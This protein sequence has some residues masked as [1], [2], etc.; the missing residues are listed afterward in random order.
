MHKAITIMHDIII[1]HVRENTAYCPTAFDVNAS[2]VSSSLAAD[3]ECRLDQMSCK[4]IQY[5]IQ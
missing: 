3:D 1:R 4:V 2:E 5:V